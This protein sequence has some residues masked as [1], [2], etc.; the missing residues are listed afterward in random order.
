M[1]K[2][3]LF[4]LLNVG[5]TQMDLASASAC[6]T[7]KPLVNA[8][9]SLKVSYNKSEAGALKALKNFAFS[10]SQAARRPEIVA[11]VDLSLLLANSEDEDVDYYTDRAYRQFQSEFDSVL[12]SERRTVGAPF[13]ALVKNYE[14]AMRN[15]NGRPE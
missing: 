11:F 14:D 6:P 15:G 5:W 2:Y 9:Q 4:I 7:C 1:I 10:K 8:T 12:G 13:R 3:I